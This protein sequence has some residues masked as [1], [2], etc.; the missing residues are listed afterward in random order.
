MVGA[1]GGDATG[2]VGAGRCQGKA[3]F[4]DHRL[5]D[6]VG[7]P[8]DAHRASAR[9]H[10]GRNRL[11]ARQYQGQ[12]PGPER[13]RQPLRRGRPFGDTPSGHAL[14]NHVHDDRVMRRAALGLIDSGHRP[15]I[16]R[17]GRQAIDRFRRER[18]KGPRLQRLG[19]APHRCL[20]FRP[21]LR[22]QNHCFQTSAHWVQARRTAAAG[23]QPREERWLKPAPR[24]QWPD[25]P[26]VNIRSASPRRTA[27]VLGRFAPPPETNLRF[28]RQTE[29]PLESSARRPR[30]T[31]ISLV[32]TRCTPVLL[33]LL[34]GAGWDLPAA[35]PD[36]VPLPSAPHILS[37]LK[38]EHPRLLATR[39]DFSKLRQAVKTDATLGRWHSDLKK[40]ADRILGEPPSRYEIP[41]GLRLLATSRRVLNRVQTLALLY[42]LDGDPALRRARLA[43]TGGRGQLQG[44][45][46]AALP[47]H[48]RD[49][50]RLR[51]RLRLALSTSG[52]PEQRATLRQAMVEKGLKPGQDIYEPNGGWTRARH[53]WNQV[54]N[55][56]IGMGA[57]ALADVEPEACGRFL[58]R[59]PREPPACHGR[60]RAGRRVGRR[61]GLLE[62]RHLLQ[63]RLP[64]RAADS[65]L[66]TD[67]GLSD[68]P[69]FSETGL[70]P[71]YLRGPTGRS[72]NYADG[73]DA[74]VIRPRKCSGWRASSTSRPAL[75]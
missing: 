51:H 74:A 1:G 62:L 6:R 5:D 29:V 23:F 67:F 75:V 61:P 17:I 3:T 38:K 58:A 27:A 7:R 36:L 26:G 73:G 25:A 54:C 68:I 2:Q 48:R 4:A 70:F 14:A 22:R 63:R 50:A 19:R 60:V 10:D 20:Q 49:D 66:G 28:V 21:R 42:R 16:Q 53:N 69:G 11:R 35:A 40:Q 55:G 31:D 57:L 34:A 39:E 37:L 32:M 9:G 33:L 56:G 30:P 65:A 64:G 15:L 44:L 45:E 24:T 41:D 71:I 47:R 12:R 59:R 72:F 18:H 8:A 46:P 43:G 13:V 52:R